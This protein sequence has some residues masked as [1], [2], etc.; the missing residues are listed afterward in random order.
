MRGPSTSATR[1]AWSGDVNKYIGLGFD[2]YIFVNST[3]SGDSVE[4][5][6]SIQADAGYLSPLTAADLAATDWSY[7]S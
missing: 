2:R 3:N 7:L 5:R 6:Q 1:S 4:I